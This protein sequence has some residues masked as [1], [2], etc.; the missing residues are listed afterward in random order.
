MGEC[1][2]GFCAAKSRGKGQHAERQK[3]DREEKQYGERMKHVAEACRAEKSS[4]HGVER[5]GDWLEAREEL[6]PIGKDGH[7]EKHSTGN[8]GHSEEKPLGRVAAFEEE[9]VTGGK[10]AEAGKGLERNKK[11]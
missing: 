1:A 6:E 3:S 11:D 8:A 4:A 5:V 9:K 7:G 10:Y 2:C